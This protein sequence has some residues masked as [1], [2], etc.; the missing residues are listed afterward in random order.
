MRFST[1][2]LPGSGGVF[3]PGPLDFRVEEVPL[4]E[5]CGEGEHL[6]VRFEK[7]GLTTREVIKRAAA[8]L[9]APEREIGYAGLKDKNA[10]TVQT[11]SVPR[12]DA[13]AVSR[14]EMEGLRVLSALRHKNKLKTGH[15]AG[16][17]FQCRLRDAP[18]EALARAQATLAALSAHGLPNFYG[19]QRFGRRGDNA[20]QAIGVLRKGPRAAGSKWRARF[21]VSAL[22]S[23]LFNAC[24]D[25]RMDEGTFARVQSGD[26]MVKNVS[27]G[28][29]VCDS[30]D[31]DQPRYDSWEISITGPI[32]GPKMRR[33][34]DGSYAAAL[35]DAVLA[36]A[37]LSLDDFRRVRKMAP[38]TR[39]PLRARVEDASAELEEAGDL[40]I[41]FRL[42]PGSYATILVAEVTKHHSPP[43]ATDDSR[44]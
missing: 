5:P 33:P 12:V 21:L 19:S 22:Q 35:E 34:T 20:Q 25:R 41:R 3:T 29:F 2:D 38:G 16:N 8:V 18:P 28:P 17:V 7:V 43:A 39:R 42:P 10:T 15:L 13:A 9:D 6:Y 40:V 11:I 27:G 31:D 24:L 32:V 4:Y 36:D 14:L 1:F 26:V 23:E 30:P 37:G 44:E